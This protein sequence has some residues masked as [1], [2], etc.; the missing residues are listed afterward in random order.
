MKTDDPSG[1]F[2]SKMMETDFLGCLVNLLQYWS[3]N[4][5]KSSIKAITALVK[6]SKLIYYFVLYKD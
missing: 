3:D 6:F 1:N 4:A 2:R 5:K